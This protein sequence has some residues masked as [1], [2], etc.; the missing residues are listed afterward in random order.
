MVSALRSSTAGPRPRAHDV[1]PRGAGE[2]VASRP[3][4]DPRD[5]ASPY[6][7]VLSSIRGHYGKRRSQRT[8]LPIWVRRMQQG[9]PKPS[10][11]SFGLPKELG[12]PRADCGETKT[13]AVA[14]CGRR[15]TSPGT[16]IQR[17][18]GPPEVA[19]QPSHL[20]AYFAGA[21]SRAALSL[22]LKP[23]F[24]VSMSLT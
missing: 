21:T 4:P 23:T 16:H 24:T 13:S 7:V 8:S 11:S 17:Q 18:S 2:G 15:S 19:L 5:A 6:G 20:G 1:P 10:R 3:N 22:I 9:T 14:A 12:A